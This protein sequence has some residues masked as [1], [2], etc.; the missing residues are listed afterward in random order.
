MTFM[1]K[2]WTLVTTGLIAAFYG[3]ILLG[4]AVLIMWGHN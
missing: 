3:A 2:F 1:D 4:A